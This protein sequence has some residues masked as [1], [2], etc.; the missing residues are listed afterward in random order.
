M[1][2]KTI[3]I[4]TS[5]AASTSLNAQEIVRCV[6]R[7]H[8]NQPRRELS[9]HEK[10]GVYTFEARTCPNLGYDCSFGDPDYENSGPV[11]RD[12]FNGLLTRVYHSESVS[13]RPFFTLYRDQDGNGM[14]I[15]FYRNPECKF[16]D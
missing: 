16:K 10:E 8:Q 4:V 6:Q 2:M 15:D 9:I 3:T 7:G 5:L 12:V 14:E 1:L 11:E 13:I